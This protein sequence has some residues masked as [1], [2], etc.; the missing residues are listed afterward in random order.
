MVKSSRGAKK[1]RSKP[2][3]NSAVGFSPTASPGGSPASKKSGPAR[4]CPCGGHR[5]NRGPDDREV[6]TAFGP[7]TLTRRHFGC[8]AC[9]TAGYPADGLLGLDGYLSPR[10]LRLA[11]R[12]T[13]DQSFDVA[14]DRLH[15]SCGILVNGETLRR[16]CTAAATAMAEWTRTQPAAA[17]PFRAA[18][19]E[20]EILV[21]AGKVNTTEGWRDY[22]AIVFDKRPLGPMATPDEWTTRDLPRPTARVMF[23]DIVGIDT[24]RLTWRQ[25]AD[26]LGIGSGPDLTMLG[27]GAEWIWNATDARFAN[28]RQVLD[29]FHLLEYVGA[30]SKGLYT[31]EAEAKASFATGQA[32]VVAGGWTGVCSYV[33]IEPARDDTPARRTVLEALTGYAAKHAG[34]MDYPGRLAEGR[35][36]GSGLI[37]GQIKTLGLRLKAR[38]TRWVERNAVSMAASIGLSHSSCWDDYWSLAA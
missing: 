4:T 30:A 17:E 19:G 5:H 18:A 13:G 29:V 27:D 32:A 35:T 20:V 36:I 16:H 26:R 12:L 10:V 1:L 23:A 37:E 21:D 7:L 8:P 15:E 6:L 14:A 31:N 25:W 33:A 11:C 38:G 9:V 22:K 24:F 3:V 34:R 2:P 28:C